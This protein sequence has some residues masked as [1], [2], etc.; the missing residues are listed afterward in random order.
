MRVDTKSTAQPALGGIRM[1][2][3]DGT[4]DTDQVVPEFITLSIRRDGRWPDH[5]RLAEEIAVV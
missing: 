2:V 1:Q 3:G 4:R 5:G